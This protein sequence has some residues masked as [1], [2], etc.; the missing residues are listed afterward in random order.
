MVVR[1]TTL[2][3]SALQAFESLRAS[4][5][6]QNG[7]TMRGEPIHWSTSDASVARVIDNGSV[8][9]IGD[10]TATISATSG[11]ISG[12]AAI[13]VDVPAAVLEFSSVTVGGAHSCG[14]TTVHGAYCWGANTFGQLGNGENTDSNVPVIVESSDFFIVR[15]VTAGLTHNCGLFE[16]SFAPRGYCWGRDDVG[17]TNNVFGTDQ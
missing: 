11:S 5:L 9:S 15:S 2:S 8:R 3:F 16:P 10:G 14:V 6:D 7:R 1:P 17:Q 4:V 13:T 12:T